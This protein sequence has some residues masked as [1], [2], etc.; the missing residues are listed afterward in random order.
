MV[1]IQK[2]MCLNNFVHGLLNF[3]H[4]LS[5]EAPNGNLIAKT[6]QFAFINH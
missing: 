4:A 5:S 6:Y 1:Y 2:G 3:V